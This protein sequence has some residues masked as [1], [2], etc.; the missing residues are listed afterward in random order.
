MTVSNLLLSRPDGDGTTAGNLYSLEGR[1]ED[2]K[3]ILTKELNKYLTL[4]L[5]YT[6]HQIRRG[7]DFVVKK[8]RAYL[9]NFNSIL[10]VKSPP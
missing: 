1:K 10:N 7:T 4:S 3:F 8:S 2:T 5:Y 9:L 6:S